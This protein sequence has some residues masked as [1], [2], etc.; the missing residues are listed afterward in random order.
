MRR[1]GRVATAVLGAVLV[2]G[3]LTGCIPSSAPTPAPAASETPDAEPTPEATPTPEPTALAD[4]DTVLTAEG[5]ADLAGS[6][7]VL[8]EFRAGSW[9]YFLVHTTAAEG[10]VCHWGGGGDVIVDVGQLAM[11]EATWETTRVQ[12]EAEGYVQDDTV[13]VGFM[14][15]PDVADENYPHRGF[16]YR[17]G[18]LYYVSYMDFLPFL[19]AFQS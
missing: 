14:D 2:A 17:D 9:D 12:L 10:V 4:C 13:V 7:L 8:K 3:A 6:N 16:A 18:V 1:Y 19:Q 5:Y 15:G 11:D